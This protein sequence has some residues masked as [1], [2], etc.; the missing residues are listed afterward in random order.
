MVF[1]AVLALGFDAFGCFLGIGNGYRSVVKAKKGPNK[2]GGQR[3]GGFRK[4][5]D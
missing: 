1:L 4:K 2:I 3:D 5:P